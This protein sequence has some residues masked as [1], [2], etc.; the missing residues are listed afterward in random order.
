MQTAHRELLELELHEHEIQSIMSIFRDINELGFDNV[1]KV[2]K[3]QQGAGRHMST[4]NII[5]GEHKTTCKPVVVCL[6]R[7]LHR[8][9]PMCLQKAL[10]ALRLHL[11]HCFSVT[12]TVILITDAWCP[13]AASGSLPDLCAHHARGVRFRAFLTG[14]TIMPISLPLS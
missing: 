6:A 13:K 3:D 1:I 2:F 9:S 12:T 11:I 7:G 14:N 5:P 4:I 10:E 8:R